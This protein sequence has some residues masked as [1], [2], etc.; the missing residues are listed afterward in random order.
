METRK[1]I[2]W[3]NYKEWNNMNKFLNN[4][5][6][7]MLFYFKPEHLIIRKSREEIKLVFA[8]FMVGS[9]IILCY[10]TSEKPTKAYKVDKN[11]KQ[12]YEIWKNA[13]FI[14]Y[15]SSMDL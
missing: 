1:P 13:K 2:H 7:Y 5:D 15:C 3:M 4:I 6:T 14:R 8:Y 12:T 11:Y 10:T 9:T